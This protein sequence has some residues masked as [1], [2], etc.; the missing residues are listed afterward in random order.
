MTKEIKRTVAELLAGIW[1][2]VVVVTV[3]TL[4]VM[5]CTSGWEMSHTK[6][7]LGFIFGGALSCFMAVHMAYSV[8]GAVDK[9]ED[10]ALNHTRK[11]YA[12]RTVIVFAA[13][14]ALYYTGWVN[15]ISLFVGTFALK[16]AVYMQ[17][18]IHRIAFGKDEDA[19]SYE[20][21]LLS[22][23]EIEGLNQNP[24]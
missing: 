16:P 1:I 17:P 4:L 6:V 23:E 19:G 22:E 10:G 7:L 15:L 12:I 13:I 8:E 14:V 5:G 9:G 24:E 20:E 2:F 21:Q 18:L 11:M 3:V